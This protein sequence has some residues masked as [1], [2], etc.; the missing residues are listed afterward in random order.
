MT[1]GSHPEMFVLLQSGD[2]LCIVSEQG[3]QQGT[4]ANIACLEG[5]KWKNE[6]QIQKD[7][8]GMNGGN[9]S[10][11]DTMDT[12]CLLGLKGMVLQYTHMHS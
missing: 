9:S 11:E 2:K 4:K 8:P 12:V 3:S 1:C 10:S 5:W 7:K 6:W